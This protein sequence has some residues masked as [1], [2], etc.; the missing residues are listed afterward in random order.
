M[1]IVEYTTYEAKCDGCGVMFGEEETVRPAA[2]QQAEAEGWLWV[3]GPKVRSKKRIYCPKCRPDRVAD[4][5]AAER[6][7]ADPDVPTG[8]TDAF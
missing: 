1:P 6:V 2:I 5:N 8:E 4:D 3:P 7:A